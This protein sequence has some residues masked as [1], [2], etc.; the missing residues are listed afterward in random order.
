MT[1]EE[2]EA[3]MEFVGEAEKGFC[4]NCGY[5]LPCPEEI[6]IPNIFRFE[7]YYDRYNLK[8]CARQQYRSQLVNASACSECEQCLELCPYGVPIPE[9]L[10]TIHQTL[11]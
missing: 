6:V 1:A 3:L 11:Q 9:K 5:Y 8:E 10:K 4:R 2:I 7:S